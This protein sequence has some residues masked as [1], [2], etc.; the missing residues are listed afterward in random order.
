[1]RTVLSRPAVGLLVAGLLAA[2]LAACST[3]SVGLPYDPGKAQHALARAAAPSVAI[4]GVTDRRKNEPS[5]LGAIRSGFGMPLKT[6]ETPAP[7]KDV[8]A[9][10][11]ADGLKARNLWAPDGR[12]AMAITIDK[13]D[14][15]QYVRREAH[16]TI[17]IALT[18]KATGRAIFDRTYEASEVN[19]QFGD[20]DN[21]IFGSVDE[22]RKV[23]N[24]TLQ[25]VVDKAL[26]D[27]QLR[28]T[29]ATR[30]I[31]ARE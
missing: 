22:F 9:S 17:R 6:L 25:E 20:L 21:G 15:S 11:F 19:G 31:A 3:S 4:A 18:E 12:I 14:C 23:A 13:F 30:P 1:M 16:A 5:E 10:A 26:D 2:G 29:L 28:Q 7:V 24:A 8:V 27:P